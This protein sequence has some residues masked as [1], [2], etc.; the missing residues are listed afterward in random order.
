MNTITSKRGFP[1]FAVAA[2]ATLAA[3]PA[4]PGRAM[5]QDTPEAQAVESPSNTDISLGGKVI[6]TIREGSGG[7]SASQ[8]AE[9]I[10]RRLEPILRMPGIKPS[11]V[12]IRDNP[13][14]PY[15]SI[16]V[17]DRLLVTVTQDMARSNNS[18]PEVLAE[19]YAGRLRE[20]LPQLTYETG[21]R[22][23]PGK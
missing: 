11:E 23:A 14:G 19:M 21:P 1:L 12:T 13:E 15:A 10:R 6:M 4:I 2:I 17:R 9:I 22:N 3:V 7:Y 20:L 18:T 8:R 5:A 16:Y